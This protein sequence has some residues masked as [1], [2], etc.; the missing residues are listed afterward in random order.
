MKV[1]TFIMFWKEDGIYEQKDI[2]FLFGIY[3]IN[4]K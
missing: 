2:I 3:R 4:E 1:C